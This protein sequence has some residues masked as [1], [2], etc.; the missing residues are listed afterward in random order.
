[1]RK[2]ASG[3]EEYCSQKLAAEE[4]IRGS[5]SSTVFNNSTTGVKV[6]VHVDNFTFRGTKSHLNQVCANMKKWHELK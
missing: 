3:W 6:V 5:G 2:A 4:F 1:M